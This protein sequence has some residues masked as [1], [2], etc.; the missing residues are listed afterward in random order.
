MTGGKVSSGLEATVAF[1]LISA[2]GELR[3]VD[4]TIDTGFNGQLT[5]PLD[6]IEELGFEHVGER[7]ALLGNG[8][9]EVLRA[10]LGRAVWDDTE[11]PVLTL[12]GGG[13]LIGMRLLADSV[14]TI[15]IRSGGAVRIER[16]P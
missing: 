6:L 7:E 12:A 2:A 8:A 1:G 3:V 14:L 4:A 9:T 5:L 16:L 10:Y 15:E 11:R 13:P